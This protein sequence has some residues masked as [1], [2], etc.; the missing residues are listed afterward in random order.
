MKKQTVICQ[1]CGNRTA[2]DTARWIPVRRMKGREGNVGTCCQPQE[3]KIKVV[4]TDQETGDV[5]DACILDAQ[6]LETGQLV[7]ATGP[8]GSLYFTTLDR[9]FL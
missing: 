1:E 6:D 5:L 3:R 4:V 2:A 9:R 7:L 8:D